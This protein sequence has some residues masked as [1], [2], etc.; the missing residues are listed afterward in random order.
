M[1]DQKKSMTVSVVTQN[2]VVM[3]QRAISQ[4]QKAPAAKEPKK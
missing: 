3:G 4:Q 2:A 1:K